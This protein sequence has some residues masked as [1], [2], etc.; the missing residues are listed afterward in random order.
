M[1]RTL[2]DE[3]LLAMILGSRADRGR[4]IAAELIKHAG[5]IGAL[6]RATAREVAQAG[7]S[8]RRAARICAAFE[9]GRRAVGAATA[10][11]SLER[12]ED[13]YQLLAP[14]MAGLAQEIFVVIGID[15]RNRIL[16]VVEVGRGSVAECE[17]VG[18][19]A[20]DRLRALVHT[21]TFTDTSPAGDP[22]SNVPAGRTTSSGHCGQS[23]NTVP[24]GRDCAAATPA[25]NTVSRPT[26]RAAQ[27]PR[28]EVAN[29]VIPAPTR[30]TGGDSSAL[31]A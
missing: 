22:I 25:A 27:T 30:L 7:V 14:R 20:K 13:V 23:R 5:G 8:Q 12:A 28:I 2:G 15:V 26:N 11:A 24:G 3:D 21:F 16:D 10:R 19:D 29:I 9:L 1:D 6:S 18:I 17:V 4:G 31:D